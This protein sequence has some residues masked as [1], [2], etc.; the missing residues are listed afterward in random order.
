MDAVT[1][2]DQVQT[3]LATARRVACKIGSAL[4]VDQETGQLREDWL[5]GLAN[6]IAHLRERGQDVILISSGAIALGRRVLNLASGTLSLEQAQ[7]AAAVGQT[8]LIRAWEEALSSH[9]LLA[10]QVLLTLDDTQDRRRYLNGRS[11]LASL[12]SMGAIPVVNENDTVATDEIRYGD[13][14]RLAARVALMA[15]ADVLVLLSDVDGLYTSDPRVDPSARH[16]PAISEITPEIEAMAGDAGTEVGSGGMRTKILA[17]KTALSGGC[18]LAV[19]LGSCPRPLTAVVNGARATWFVPSTG[20]R[21]ARKQWIAGMKPVGTVVIDDGAARALRSGRSLLP[22]GVREIIGTFERGDPVAIV[23]DSDAAIGAALVG[24]SATEACAIV[25]ARS[26]A[27]AEI[28]GYPRRAAMA[29]R[30]DM[31]LWDHDGGM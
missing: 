22:A 24:Y 23:T 8:R 2:A 11:T 5:R 16:L 25:G 1:M 17:A 4:L 10:A 26:D 13:N 21:A 3:P 18:A 15:G 29:H 20:P 27:I 30:D 6:D 14:D 7:A 9:G 12:M 31:V 19:T 28:L